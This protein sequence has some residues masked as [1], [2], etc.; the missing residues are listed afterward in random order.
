MINRRDACKTICLLPFVEINIK[1]YNINE[2]YNRG[3][4]QNLLV[5]DSESNENEISKRLISLI[6]EVHYLNKDDLLFK[7]RENVFVK[8][9][10]GAFWWKNP[11][12]IVNSKCCNTIKRIFANGDVKNSN[13]LNIE[14][15]KIDKKYD[16]PLP[17]NH[18]NLLIFE[19]SCGHVLFGSC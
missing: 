6:Q 19:F 12:E 10:D 18:K 9:D 4:D 11:P 8:E 17:C 1:S 13:E 14:I 3:Y 16:L 5:F 7:D 2:M 15:V